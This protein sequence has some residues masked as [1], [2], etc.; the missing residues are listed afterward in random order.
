MNHTPGSSMFDYNFDENNSLC[1][2][3]ATDVARSRYFL[4]GCVAAFDAPGEWVA[5]EAGHLLVRLPRELDGADMNVVRL[6]GKPVLSSFEH[7]EFCQAYGACV[8][9]L[10][11]YNL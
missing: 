11:I 4:D 2:K 10:L 9:Q 7:A 1:A 3:Y 5:D 8:A 6:E